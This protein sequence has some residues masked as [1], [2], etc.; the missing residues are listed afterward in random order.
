MHA[1]AALPW[2]SRSAAGG[3]LHVQLPFALTRWRR[4]VVWRRRGSI[5]TALVSLGA[6]IAPR[7]AAQ[8][9]CP[10]LTWTPPDTLR[11][12]GDRLY[13]ETPEVI[14]TGNRIALFGGPAWILRG[15]APAA[16][17]AGVRLTRTGSVFRVTS[18]IPL[19]PGTRRLSVPRAAELPDGGVAVVWRERLLGSPGADADVVDG[20]IWRLAGWTPPQRVVDTAAH[21][22]WSASRISRAV[23]IAGTPTVVVSTDRALR[24]LLLRADSTGWRADPIGLDTTYPAIAPLGP[25]T[26]AL[27]LVSADGRTHANAAFLARGDVTGWSR[28][29]ELDARDTGVVANSMLV[30]AP[31]GAVA[32]WLSRMH[33]GTGILH[34]AAVDEATG[35]V[36]LTTTLPVVAAVEAVDAVW[37]PRGALAVLM[38]DWTRA[39]VPP[40][41]ALWRDGNWVI[42]QL[43][44]V[45][46]T[47]V[48]Q[49]RLIVLPDRRLLAVW[50][51]GSDHEHLPVTLYATAA[52]TA[53][54]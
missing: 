2:R 52:E 16:D 9:R 27:T 34:G 1:S 50:S 38:A 17:V 31:R 47:V 23:R 40:M 19:P 21:V 51:V 7:A 4:D 30:R 32:T 49:P 28:P 10:A 42:S 11:I 46:G 8:R 53:C 22:P 36:R 44:A 24:S 26:L 43:P 45:N 41:V 35:A 25:S 29:T 6:C 3:A 48:P 14:A 13:V 37:T 20:A 5:A 15:D 39:R 12:N 54:P 33:D 18:L